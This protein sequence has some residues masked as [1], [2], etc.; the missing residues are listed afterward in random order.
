MPGDAILGKHSKQDHKHQLYADDHIRMKG[1]QRH[2]SDGERRGNAPGTATGA[3]MVLG[4]GGAVRG[5]AR[6]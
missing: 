5:G 6:D 1:P 3:R 4:G 2:G